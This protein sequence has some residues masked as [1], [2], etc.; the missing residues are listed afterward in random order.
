VLPEAATYDELVRR[1]R[2]SIPERVNM[3][4]DCCDRWADGSG[5]P[6]ILHLHTDG[7]VER[8][9]FDHLQAW[10]NRLANLLLAHGVERG[11]R[12]AILLGQRPETAGAHIAVYKLGAVAVPMFTL[13]GVDAIEYRLADSGA[14]VLITGREGAGKV[15]ELRGRLADLRR[16]FSIDGAAEGADDLGREIERASDRFEPIVTGPDDPALIS[17]TSG[18][19]GQAKGALHGQRVLHG[20][21]PGIELAHD[22]FPKPGDLM[23]TPADWAWLGGLMNAL[24]PSLFHGVPVLAARAGK[25]D[26]EEAFRLM[27]EQGVRNAFLGPTALKMLRTAGPPRERPRLRSVGSAGEAMGAELLD[28]GREVFGLTINEFYG[29]TECNAVIGNSAALFPV[30]PG[31]MGRAVPGHDVAILDREGRPL[32]PGAIGDVAVRRP[33]PAMFLGYWNRPE[34][35]AAKF[36]GDWL[37]TGDHGRMDEDGTFHFVGRDDDVI[38]SAGYRIGPGE[39]EDCLLRHP[40]IANAAAVGIP[41]ALRTERVKAFVVL[42][43]G[44]AA[45]DALAADIQAFVRTRLAAHEYPREVA[46]LD[47]LPTTTTGKVIRRALRESL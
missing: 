39:I 37:V 21:L 34:A 4:V 35:T 6:A 47:A 1:F 25:F 18:T 43:P 8:W 28:W 27:A 12:V 36:R 26:P 22:L 19:T 2:W 20:H 29:Q 24:M 7:R 31:A 41:D 5:R 30:T 46:F 10:S 16:V 42:K 3:G 15:A 14:K 11:D 44:F 13:F 17:Y 32:A 40:A 38:T 33:D 23:W 45:G 9:T